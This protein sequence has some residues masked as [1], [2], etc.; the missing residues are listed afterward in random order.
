MRVQKVTKKFFCG[1]EI[2]VYQ[3]FDKIWFKEVEVG[4]FELDNSDDEFYLHLD[5]VYRNK[6]YKN[7]RY[8]EKIVNWIFENI[9]PDK[10]TCLP[11]EK[12]RPYYEKLGFRP[13]R[14]IHDDIY[15]IKEKV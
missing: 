9:K 2:E 7:R 15:Y 13:F 11:L 12:Y 6:R 4:A 1:T 8:L 10:L 14:M 3:V 5:H